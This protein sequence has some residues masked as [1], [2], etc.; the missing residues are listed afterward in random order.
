MFTALTKTLMIDS[1]AE[2]LRKSR[3]LTLGHRQVIEV[4]TR[5][6]PKPKRIQRSLLYFIKILASVDRALG[7]LCLME[8]I[9]HGVPSRTSTSLKT[10]SLSNNSKIVDL[11]RFIGL[12]N[13]RRCF[14]IAKC[15]QEVLKANLI[16]F[17][18]INKV[19]I[20]F[21]TKTALV[22]VSCPQIK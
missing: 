1:C 22:R 14:K 15:I 10:A 2:A 6:K 8:T 19:A 11:F 9:D 18:R 21:N 16:L 20:N 17:Q 5:K 7:S 12:K 13:S 3:W 4:V